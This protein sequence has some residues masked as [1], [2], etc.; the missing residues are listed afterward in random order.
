MTNCCYGFLSRLKIVC[1]LG[2]IAGLG[3]AQN[4]ARAG[5]VSGDNVILPTQDDTN[6]PITSPINSGASVDFGRNEPN[7]KYLVTWTVADQS[8]NPL[9]PG[10]LYNKVVGVFLDVIEN[11]PDESQ[12]GSLVSSLPTGYFLITTDYDR[13]KTPQSGG[14]NPTVI[15]D[16]AQGR[17]FVVYRRSYAGSENR[18]IFGRTIGFDGK[19]GEEIQ[20]L[21]ASSDSLSAPTIALDSTNDR[22]LVAW[23]NGGSISGALLSAISLTTAPTPVS[24]NVNGLRPSL[25]FNTAKG[26]YLLA[27]QANTGGSNDIVAKRF[28]AT[29]TPVDT[30]SIVLTTD[31]SDQTNPKATYN[32]DK[33]EYA[34]IWTDARNFA[35]SGQNTYGSIISADGAIPVAESALD[36]YSINPA[37]GWAHSENL[38]LLE[39]TKDK[40]SAARDG[41]LFGRMLSSNL[42]T[43]EFPSNFVI[44]KRAEAQAGARSIAFDTAYRK[45]LTVWTRATG[46]GDSVIA[47]QLLNIG[48]RI[49]S[50]RLTVGDNPDPL[51][52][53]QPFSYTISATNTGTATARLVKVNTTLPVRMSYTDFQPLKDDNSTITCKAPTEADSRVV[54]DLGNVKPG[55]T[56]SFDLLLKP[57]ADLF[58]KVTGTVELAW[59]NL[60]AKPRKK[61]VDT[62]IIY[63]GS[64]TVTAPGKDVVLHPGE[65]Q[66]LTWRLATESGLA[67]TTFA[68]QTYRSVNAGKT[69]IPLEGAAVRDGSKPIWN[70]PWTVPVVAGNRSS[71]LIRVEGT[72]TVTDSKGNTSV[73]RIAFDDSDPFPIEVVKLT[74][75]NGGPD[76]IDAGSSQTVSWN[77]YATQSP[78][79]VVRLEY[80]L[81]KGQ[82]WK[83]IK[84]VPA[85]PAGSETWSVPLLTRN[86]AKAKVRVKL[87]TAGGK[88]VG[89]DPSDQAFSI[90]VLDL[91]GPSDAVSGGATESITWKTYVTGSEVAGW[92]LL[93]S[94]DNG[95]SWKTV[96][97]GSG[98]PEAH[99]WTVP[100]LKRQ[101]KSCKLRLILTDSVGK[102]LAVAQSK[103]FRILPP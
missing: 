6:P 23:S 61:Q 43:E 85:N 8:T 3:L 96:G 28:S 84:D 33:N 31:A 38:Y 77:Y 100:T 56:K 95:G 79:N 45:A 19:V 46:N 87:L 75:P 99:D 93:L 16:G 25:A 10:V 86:A 34:V 60:G 51:V 15:F 64:L 52:N 39:S 30:N 14:S 40:A 73:G 92:K 78:V 94:K 72:A 82:R 36:T 26:E 97:E 18:G 69:W 48:S 90:R 67:G 101:A 20:I 21:S 47:A 63:P 102:R 11:D 17:F 53:G 32:P 81:N 42:S 71:A 35:S 27:Y 103:T 2:L 98:N 24:F 65:E 70:Q 55:A 1:W 91:T 57:A 66:Q 74:A 58:G 50:M 7:H 44:S 4:L 54:C 22:Y 29:G 9:E 62:E 5:I 12:D 59:D 76:P 49:T 88:P 89:S 13:D 41:F 37:I 83:R 80:S 68:F